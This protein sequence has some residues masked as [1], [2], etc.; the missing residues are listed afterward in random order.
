VGKLKFGVFLP[1]Y[2]FQAKTPTEQF[3]ILKTIVLDCER[4]GYDSVWLDDHVQ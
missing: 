3:E 1:F 2:A 4:Y